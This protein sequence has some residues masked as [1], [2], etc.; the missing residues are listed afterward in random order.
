GVTG[1]TGATGVTGATGATGATGVTGAAGATGATGVTGA[2][3]ATGATGVAGVTGETGA[4]GSTGVTGATGSFQQFQVSE[5]TPNTAGSSAIPIT[6]VATTLKTITI[7]GV[8]TGSRVWLT[9]IVGWESTAGNT[10]LQLQILRGTTT[11]F[12]INQHTVAVSTFGATSVNHVDLTPG[13]GNVSYSLAALT[14][15]GTANAIGAITF[16][17][18]LIQP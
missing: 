9:G 8:P 12:S 5:N 3:G 14:N 11:I 17:G 7:I 6:S 16:T 2:A 10:S 13:T 1:A 18:A 4:T 15:V